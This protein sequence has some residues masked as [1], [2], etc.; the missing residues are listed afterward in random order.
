MNQDMVRLAEWLERD[1]ARVSEVLRR[2]PEVEEYGPARNVT[3]LA[4]RLELPAALVTLVER[5]PLPYLQVIEATH[6]LGLGATPE[7]LSDLL[8]RS[9]PEHAQLVGDILEDLG[10]YAVIWPTDDGGLAVADGVRDLWPFPLGLSYSVRDLLHVLQ[11]STLRNMAKIQGV[12]PLPAGRLDLETAIARNLSDTSWVTK[13]PAQAPPGFAAPL[14]ELAR[15]RSIDAEVIDDDDYWYYLR[16]TPRDSAAHSA[17]LLKQDAYR[18]AGGLGLLLG[19]EYSEGWQMPAEVGLALRGDDY[20]APFDPRRPTTMVTPVDPRSVSAAAEAAVTAFHQQTLA[21]LDAISGKELPLTKSGGLAVRDLNRL[22]KVA[23]VEPSAARMALEIADGAGLISTAGGKIQT[24][25]DFALWRS[26]EA[27]QRFALLLT[28]WWRLPFSPSLEQDADG[29]T[30]RPLDRLPLQPIGDLVRQAVMSSLQAHPSDQAVDYESFEATLL[31]D[32]AILRHV[33]PAGT[34]PWADIWAEAIALGLLA[35]GALTPLGR[36]VSET[37]LSTLAQRAEGLLPPSSQT[38]VFGSD[39]TVM[40]V[41]SPSA[42][43]SRLLD[44]AAV[45]ESLGAAITWR[46]SRTSLREAMDNGSSG[47]QLE[48]DLLAVAAD[49]LPQPLRY[50]IRDLGRRHGEFRLSPAQSVIHSHDAARLAEAAADRSLRSLGLRLVAPTVLTSQR[51]L[52]ETMTALRKAGF[53]PMPD[54]S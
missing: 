37:D 53:M 49:G 13:Q 9:E 29:K 43:I 25:P 48:A 45:R 28:A 39:L 7:V 46:F 42:A 17:F 41:G 44:S 16:Q 5:L 2:R 26:A 15:H 34:T 50:L 30:I 20:H 23:L 32:R 19:Q 52:E 1:P 10:H 18:W 22:A 35:A 36:S 12:S 3:E 24:T 21:V 4:R 8:R 31:W 54:L 14:L 38:A 27:P 51:S 33:S 11:T 47:E 40:V 6:A